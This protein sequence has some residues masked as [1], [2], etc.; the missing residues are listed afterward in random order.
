MT[1]SATEFPVVVTGASG[2]LGGSVIRELLA[3]G[4]PVL[5]LSRRRIA[6]PDGVT[7]QTVS[8]YRSIELPQGSTVLHLAGEAD[9][10]AANRRG[11]KHVALEIALAAAVCDS[12]AGRIVFASSAQIY[13]DLREQPHRPD[14]APE[15]DTPYARAKIAT[16][17]MIV[18]RGGAAARL[19][20]LYGPN[21]S[22]TL[23]ADIL[24]QIPGT[25]PLRVREVASRRDH[26]WHADAA[27]ALTDMALGT[28]S[29]IFNVASGRVQS[30]GEVAAAALRAAG[31][32]DRPVVPAERP[33]N[34]SVIALD[35]SRTTEFF[36]WHPTTVLEE[37][38]RHLIEDKK[39]KR[40]PE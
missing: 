8:D 14:E 10:V 3:R 5:A 33:K 25:G 20:N 7:S 29:G 18:E 37:G 38:L 30:V 23:I 9:V 2:F 22:G 4:L 24:A 31:E 28:A 32:H 16:E 39:E 27:R 1:D 15:N 6:F 21:A 12:A 35:I 11:E 40:L 34:A 19:S 36:G 13:G 17:R 26:L